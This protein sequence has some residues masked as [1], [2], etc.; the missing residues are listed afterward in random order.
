MHLQFG[1]IH[2]ISNQHCRNFFN[3]RNEFLPKPDYG[4]DN[5]ERLLHLFPKEETAIRSLEGLNEAAK[6][7]P[8]LD[9]QAVLLT[10]EHYTEAK[11]TV[12]FMALASRY[13]FSHPDPV[14]AAY[15][16][17]QRHVNR[18]FM[19][20][21]IT[22]HEKSLSDFL[23]KPLAEPALKNGHRKSLPPLPLLQVLY[24]TWRN[25]RENMPALSPWAA[26]AHYHL[27]QTPSEDS[28]K[29]APHE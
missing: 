12:P 9:N 17:H 5:R 24:E 22:R 26:Y 28:P 19:A 16:E 11:Q 6:C 21:T 20:Q 18:A 2:L 8:Y 14:G 23:I 13:S 29:T 10:G 27:A 25:L 15:E 3:H 4:I 7:V 1:A